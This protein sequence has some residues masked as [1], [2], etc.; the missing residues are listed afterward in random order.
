L[1]NKITSL[2]PGTTYFDVS[3]PTNRLSAAPTRNQEGSTMASFYGYKV[4]GYF[5]DK[6]EVDAAPKQDGAEAGTFRY[7]DTNGD[8]KIS[9]DDRTILGSPIP[10]FTGGINLKVT[11]KNFDIETYLYASL[12]NQIFNMTKWYTNFYSTFPGS[13]KAET[14]KN[15]WTPS[16]LNASSPIF[17][18]KSNF[19][20]DTQPNSWYV[21]NGSYLRMTNLAVGYNVP[22]DMLQKLGMK[23]ARLS[24]STNNVFT[25]TGYSG[26]DPQVGGQADTNF[27]I[28]IGNYPVTRSYNVMVKLGF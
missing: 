14:V 18:N 2:A 1:S 17:T 13:A 23:T 27:G 11:Y 5:K 4:L 16:N 21:E 28:D 26:L 19:S 6:A 12:G 20:T 3:P 15:S 10:T 9:A 7:A 25:V 8:G 22:K 24:F